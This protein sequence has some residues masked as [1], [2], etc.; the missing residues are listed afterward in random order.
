MLSF[1]SEVL[2]SPLDILNYTLCL[3]NMFSAFLQP[4]KK[5]HSKS[6]NSSCLAVDNR[7]MNHLSD[8]QLCC[9]HLLLLSSLSSLGLSEEKPLWSL[10]SWQTVPQFFN[11]LVSLMCASFL[12]N[13]QAEIADLMFYQFVSCFS[14]VLT[15][16][17]KSSFIS[18]L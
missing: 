12:R 9:K 15:I 11:F 7:G 3:E 10:L 13:S 16:L 14:K 17:C 6:V 5:Q 2:S 4:F 1:C 8:V 18:D